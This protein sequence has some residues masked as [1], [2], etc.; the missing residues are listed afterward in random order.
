MT[1]EF[2]TPIPNGYKPGKT[3]YVIVTGSV[4]SG[5]G[6]GMITSSLCKLFADKGLNVEPI[7]L[8]AYLNVDAGTLNP[9][10]HGEV[11]VLDDGT[12][13]DM[14]LGSYERFVD[15]NLDNGNFVTSGRIYQQ[16]IE[17]ERRG[18]YLGRD[19][20]F[21][22]HVTGE[23]KKILRDLA[24][25]K[26]PDVIVIEIG[27]T[28]GDYENMFALEAIRELMFEEGEGNS[29]FVNATYIIEPPSLGEFKSKAAQLG[30][31]RLSSMGIKPDIILCRA[32]SPV[33][34]KAR[35]KISINSSV[36]MEHVIGLEDI[37]KIYELP[38]ELR[39][40]GV[41]GKIISRL[42]L[43]KK[44]KKNGDKRLAGW[45]KKNSVPKNAKKVRIGIAGKYTDVHDAY[46]SILK[47]LEHCEGKLKAKVEVG[48][49]ETTE[50]EKNR[51]KLAELKKFDGIIVPGGFGKRGCEG[52]IAV[53][54]YCRGKNIPY[55]GLCLGAQVA[56]I[57]FA[58]EVCGLKQANST[59]FAP[60]CKEP[61][62]DLLPEQMKIEAMGGNMRLGGRDV[63]LKRGTIAFKLHG[64]K[65]TIR[66]RFRHRWEINPE[67]V[68]LLESKGMVFSGK[69]PK[70]PIMQL[71]ELPGHKF[72][73]GSQY[74]PEF[75]SRPLKP[76]P[77]FL[78]FVKAAR[79][80]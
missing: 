16:I 19:V 22:P 31:R 5:L 27:G 41:D 29:C 20:Q 71:L 79:G 34:K 33:P 35:E 18:G 45:T 38:F 6:K 63:E 77:L 15:K 25:K 30:I 48:W 1:G 76:D 74:H 43:G 60:K 56:V 13:T 7:K 44:A 37:K 17:K 64:N 68:E 50:I 42:G 58:R 46:I 80:K 8:E 23:I 10:R 51:K 73:M 55:L 65:K 21:I 24:V 69:H 49:V 36:P 72:Y 52:K 62:V 28:V 26:G 2:Y 67:F 4:M 70:Q 78:N 66:R 14:D 9:F 75:T 61:V 32:H 12:E 53:A 39:K 47:A 59:E 40:R 11:F 57:S 54:G 3:K